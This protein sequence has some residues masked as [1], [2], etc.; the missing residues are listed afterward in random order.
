MARLAAALLTVLA[1]AGSA[2]AARQASAKLRAPTGLRAFLLRPNEAETHLFS[3]TP[4]FAWNPVRGAKTYQF[5]LSTSP[6]FAGSGLVW[7]NSTLTSPA[8][9]IPVTLPWITGEPYSLYARV[10]AIGPKGEIGAWSTSYGFN[11]RWSNVPQPMTSGTGFVRWTPVDGATAYDVWYGN[12]DIGGGKSKIFSTTTNVADEREYWTFHQNTAYAGTVLWRV[13]AVR[14]VDGT[15]LPQNGLPAVSYGPWSPIYVKTNGPFT[16]GPLT[17][18]GTTADTTAVGEPAAHQLMPSF[19][20][21]GDLSLLGVSHEL[22]R[23]Y[24]FT[25]QD[26]LNVVF[27]GAIVGSPAYAPRST[28]PLLLPVNTAELAGFR[29]SYIPDGSEKK[30]TT[31]DGASVTPTEALAPSVFTPQLITTTTTSTEGSSSS[32]GSSSSGGSTSSSSTTTDPYAFPSSLSSSGAPID[33]W[34]TNWPQGRYW[35]TVV[36]VKMVT[37]TTT[38]GSGSSSVTTTTIDYVDAELAQDACALGRR[39]SFGKQSQP[40][41]TASGTPYAAGLSPSGRLLSATKPKPVFVGAPLVTW[42]PALGASAYEIQWSK[43]RYPWRPIGNKYT[44]S[45]SAS[46]PLTP[47]TWHYRVRGIDLALP[48]GAQQMAWSTPV[49]LVV[50]KPKF[51]VVGGN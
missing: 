26:C 19:Q 15:G 4:A 42:T 50:A 29:T 47:G 21:S 51:R 35:W 25:D 41:V 9:S 14:R 30:S 27:K 31:F 7:N 2:D 44:F 20:F 8:A 24:V 17:A 40:A 3:R 16:Y 23:V 28:G 13:R 33:L 45:T 5:V 39:A 49:A 38:T 36:P 46:L 6:L 32:S 37:T 43:K 18:I 11:M 1:L 10:R 48:T 22:Y 34:D 12:I